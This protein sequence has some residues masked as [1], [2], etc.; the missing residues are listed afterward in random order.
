MAAAM[1]CLAQFRK[2]PKKVL[3]PKNHPVSVLQG[4]CKVAQLSLALEL[5]QHLGAVNKAHKVVAE[6]GADG[7]EAER[8]PEGGA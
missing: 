7:E 3:V 2:G 4:L 8:P 1:K 5:V 6:G